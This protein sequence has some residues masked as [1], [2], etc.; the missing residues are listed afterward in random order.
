MKPTGHETNR[1]N[2]QLVRE[3]F[4]KNL[5]LV[6]IL[7]TLPSV[8][9]VQTLRAD[10]A[11]S[12]E[13]AAGI[14]QQSHAQAAARSPL[15]TS[16]CSFTFT[17][18]SQDT[19]L[20]YCVTINGNITQFESPA[21]FEHIAI[22]EVAE[23]YG[24]CDGTANVPYFDYADD[25]A[26]SNW[27][28]TTILSHSATSVKMTRITTDGLWTLTQLITQIAGNSSVNVAMTLKNNSLFSKSVFFLRYADVDAA[29]AF[30]NNFDGTSDSVFGW[31]SAGVNSFGM[32]LRNVGN[33]PFVHEGFGQTVSS[34]PSPC[35]PAANISRV[36]LVGIDGSIIMTYD[37]FIRPG[38]SKTLTINYKGL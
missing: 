14:A 1:L 12:R 23:G 30:N 7:W 27:G 13:A 20:K 9:F 11:G 2:K 29:G 6:L 38:Q 25:G 28:P 21:G 32:V 34:G 5:V 15:S 17:S 19:F 3:T 8:S 10:Q 16:I 26:T 31:N 35:N 24:F 36:P 33:A 22:G 4:V 37:G 18:G